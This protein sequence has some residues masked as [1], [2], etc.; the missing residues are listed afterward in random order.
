MPR[1][2]IGKL[3]H[4]QLAGLLARLPGGRRGD[5][6]VGPAIGEDA[7]AVAVE[8]RGLVVATD[9]VTFAAD[10]PGW[11]AV[12]I[13][14][15]DVA[16]MGARP[17]WFQ[18]CVLMPT[19]SPT[20]VQSVFDDIASACRELRVAVLGGH[21][22]V[23]EGLTHPIVIGTMM[24]TLDRGSP[25]RTAGARVGDAVVMTKSAGIEATSIM[26]REAGDRLIGV[27]GRRRLNRAAR[28]LF[29]P[30]ISVVREAMLAARAGATSMHDPTEGGVMTGLWEMAHAARKRFVIDVEAIPVRA[31]TAML[32]RQLGIDPLRALASGSLLV[33]VAATRASDLIRRLRRAHIDAALIGDVRRGKAGLFDASG[34]PIAFSAT[35]EVTKL[36]G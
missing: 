11:Y 16:T 24:G 14:A 12:H 28:Y 36:F 32:G 5:V 21:T 30:G 23:T 18:A 31:E 6:L 25:L 13:N 15:N 10:R 19:D 27:V 4:D 34:E 2:P 22:E 8:G 9:P 26:A 33:T 20:T 29:D 3:P 17:R 1:Y 35:D 7:A